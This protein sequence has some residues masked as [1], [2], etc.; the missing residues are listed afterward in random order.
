MCGGQEISAL[1]E[2]L[3]GGDAAIRAQILGCEP[4]A[5]ARPTRGNHLAA[6]RG[7][8]AGAVSVTALAHQLAGLIG[9]LHEVALRSPSRAAYTGAPHWASM[10]PVRP[11]NRSQFASNNSEMDPSGGRLV[12]R[13]CCAA[14]GHRRTARVPASVIVTV[15]TDNQPTRLAPAGRPL[16]PCSETACAPVADRRLAILVLVMGWHRELVAGNVGCAIAMR[17]IASL[18]PTSSGRS[19]SSSGYMSSVVALSIPGAVYLTISSGILFGALVGA[20]ASV[21]GATIGATLL[22][23]IA[24]TALGEHLIRRAGPAG[25]TDCRGLPRRCLQLSSV[26]PACSG[27]SVLPG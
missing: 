16:R 22:F 13:S 23:L 12:Y 17:W 4:L 1:P 14:F 5:A 25:A 9:P 15:P 27:V 20:L 19:R 24:R 11:R 6:A 7:L 8:H 26:P 10:R 2:P 3:H 21:V 18:P